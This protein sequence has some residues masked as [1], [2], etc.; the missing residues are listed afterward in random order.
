MNFFTIALHVP[1]T[2]PYESY[3]S[4]SLYL[5]N[6]VSTKSPATDMYREDILQTSLNGKLHQKT[7]A[8]TLQLCFSYS[9]KF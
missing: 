8:D 6:K 1:I 9:I 4:E 3:S 7:L 2:H 5:P